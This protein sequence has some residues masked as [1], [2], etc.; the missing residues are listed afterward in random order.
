MQKSSP[1]P[2]RELKERAQAPRAVKPGSPV[3]KDILQRTILSNATRGT[4]EPNR[5]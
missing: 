3:L 1:I 4:E 5:T 2:E